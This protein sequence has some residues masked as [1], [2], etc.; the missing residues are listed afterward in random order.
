[1]FIKSDLFVVAEERYGMADAQR[2]LETLGG[3]ITSS[4]GAH[5]RQLKR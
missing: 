2:V 1:M 5:V 4:M 3:A